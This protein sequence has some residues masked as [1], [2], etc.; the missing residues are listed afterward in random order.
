MTQYVFNI[1]LREILE[2]RG[3][4]Q[5]EFSELSGIREATIS[6]LVNSSRNTINKNH[7]S[8]IMDTLKLDSIDDLIEVRKIENDLQKGSH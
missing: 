4:T 7:L 1:K 5:K 3:M 2:Q 6:E 8:I